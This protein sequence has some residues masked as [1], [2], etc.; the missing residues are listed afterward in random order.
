MAPPKYTSAKNIL[1]SSTIFKQP[2]SRECTTMDRQLEIHD[3]IHNGTVQN[4]LINR[5]KIYGY[6]IQQW[7]EFI[8][9]RA[10]TG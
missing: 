4:Y 6:E 1:D 3:G 8:G 10:N 2:N 9:K 7:S 5:L